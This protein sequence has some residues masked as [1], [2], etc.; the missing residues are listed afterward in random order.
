MEI[1][2]GR[3][4]RGKQKEGGGGSWEKGKAWCGSSVH[5]FL[6]G[7]VCWQSADEAG[8]FEANANIIQDEV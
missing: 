4:K 6:T 8:L 1:H 7:A 5:M 3:R 2:S